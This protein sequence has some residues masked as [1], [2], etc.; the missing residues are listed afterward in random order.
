MA[1]AKKPSHATVP[2]IR[3]WLPASA[4][5]ENDDASL[6]PLLCN[7]KLL[8]G[9]VESIGAAFCYLVY[10]YVLYISNN[11]TIIISIYYCPSHRG[12]KDIRITITTL[13]EG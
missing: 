11:K 2:L 8:L 13:K 12:G 7:C 4:V 9:M 3:L 6:F 1:E 10:K 5:A